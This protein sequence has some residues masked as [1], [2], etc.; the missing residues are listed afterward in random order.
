MNFTDAIITKGLDSLSQN[1][2]ATVLEAFRTDGAPVDVAQFRPKFEAIEVMQDATLPA[3]GCCQTNA[4]QS[5]FFSNLNLLGCAEAAPLGQ[6][7]GTVQ[8][9]V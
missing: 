4:N 9:E 3:D 6:S 5:L 8:L 1:D 7:S 2:F